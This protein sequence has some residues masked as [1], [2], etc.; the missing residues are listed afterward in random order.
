[1]SDG[2]DTI[3]ARHKRTDLTLF[4]RHARQQLTKTSDPDE[5]STG[6]L[7]RSDIAVA[8]PLT[9]QSSRPASPSLPFITLFLWFQYFTHPS[10]ADMVA[11]RFPRSLL[12]HYCQV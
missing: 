6:R 7:A 3:G 5:Q 9:P 10:L 8:R 4:T 12:V 1:M 11:E 2:S